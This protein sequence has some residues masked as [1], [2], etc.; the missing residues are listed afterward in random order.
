MARVSIEVI[1]AMSSPSASDSS[2]DTDY[3]VGDEDVAFVP[4]DGEDENGEEDFMDE[5][6]QKYQTVQE[7]IFEELRMPLDTARALKKAW[8]EFL[9][10]QGFEAAADVI[11]SACFD[12]APSLQGLFKTPRSLMSLRLMQGITSI[13][14][15]SDNPPAM[16]A[17][18]E[19]LGSRHFDRDPQA[20]RVMILQEA[21]MNAV[22]EIFHFSPRVRCGLIAVLN[23]IGGANCYITR[24][25]SDRIKLIHNSWRVA[26]NKILGLEE[27]PSQASEAPDARTAS[28]RST[29]SSFRDLS[30]F[31][32]P[33]T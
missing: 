20:A 13:I 6:L 21:M 16:K 9:D 3:L 24:E 2:K 28:T 31:G 19:A 25:Y 10:V 15:L 1:R 12:A 18:C 14:N 23:Y 17:A 32:S 29:E 5:C 27:D 30:K 11:Y 7:D 33:V 22:E 4:E 8:A 26:N